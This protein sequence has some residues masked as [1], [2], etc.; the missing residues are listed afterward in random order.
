[1]RCVDTFDRDQGGW[2]FL[3]SFVCCTCVSHLTSTLLISFLERHFCCFYDK[4]RKKKK[5]RQ[6]AVVAMLMMMMMMMIMMI[7]MMMMDVGGI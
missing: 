1:M 6:L 4:E 2:S 7:M 3:C 5:W